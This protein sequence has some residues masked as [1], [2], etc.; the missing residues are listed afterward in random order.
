MKPLVWL[1]IVCTTAV[2]GAAGYFVIK[3]MEYFRPKTAAVA[4]KLAAKAPQI[5]LATS[6]APPK[7]CNAALDSF[8]AL[9]QPRK[10]PVKYG[11]TYHFSR[12]LS[13]GLANRYL[14]ASGERPWE[15]DSA[16]NADGLRIGHLL[17]RNDSFALISFSE[18]YKGYWDVQ[19]YHTHVVALSN[20]G[21]VSKECVAGTSTMTFTNEE[22]GRGIYY[23]LGACELKPDG[24]IYIAHKLK[25]DP[26]LQEDNRIVVDKT[27]RD[28]SQVLPSGKMRLVSNFCHFHNGFGFE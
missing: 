24:N 1:G 21:M 18:D 23:G 5:P 26:N 22:G 13:V 8:L 6:P 2:A 11:E 28:T 12:P 17:M 27:R 16:G 7:C 4:P 19:E 9:F 15:A 25:S 3:S 14:L 20:S 10:L